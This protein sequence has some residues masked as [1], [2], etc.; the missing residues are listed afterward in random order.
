MPSGVYKHKTLKEE[1]IK[2]RS[3]GF[4]DG[5]LL[6]EI[7][8]ICQDPRIMNLA[9]EN[10]RGRVYKTIWWG[11]KYLMKMVESRTIRREVPLFPDARAILYGRY[12]PECKNA[13]NQA[14]LERLNRQPPG[15]KRP[16]G[17][18]QN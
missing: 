4:R 3:L 17:V 5:R 11:M 2:P 12:H 6:N 14:N 13:K 18:S 15:G 10:C 16:F 8:Q 9:P 7:E 1:G